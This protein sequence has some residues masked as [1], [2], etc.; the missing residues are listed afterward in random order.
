MLPMRTQW[1]DGS[2]ADGSF[3]LSQRERAGV[4][5]NAWQADVAGCQSHRFAGSVKMRSNQKPTEML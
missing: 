3:S 2:A 4:R 1:R 5:E